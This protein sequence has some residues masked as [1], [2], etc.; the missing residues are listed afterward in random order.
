MRLQV[1]RLWNFK[2]TVIP[3]LIILEG[4][5]YNLKQLLRTTGIPS[6]WA[7]WRKQHYLEQCSFSREFLAFQETGRCQMPGQSFLS[8]MVIQKHNKL[9]IV[10]INNSEIKIND[11]KSNNN[12]NS[13]N[14]NKKFGNDSR[15]KMWFMLCSTHWRFFKA[16]FS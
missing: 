16:S 13:N 8:V 2:V 9:T 10:N 15:N 12:N 4:T 14:D 1:L 11:S 6:Y 3:I 7:A 5:I